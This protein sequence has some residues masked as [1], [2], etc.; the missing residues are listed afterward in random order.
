M[1]T[2]KKISNLEQFYQHVQNAG[3][4]R[5]P[6]HARRWSDGVLKTLGLHLDRSTRRTLAQALPPELAASLTRVFWLVHFRDR[7]LSAQQFQ[8]QVANRS[9][10][11]DAQFARTPIL[12]VFSGIKEIINDSELS[13]RVAAALSPEV[14][15][16]WEEA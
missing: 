16:L 12:A 8:K 7:R 14:R 1:A 6:Q 11:T 3:R 4:L 9:G 10:V 5:T 15:S 13:S 2:V